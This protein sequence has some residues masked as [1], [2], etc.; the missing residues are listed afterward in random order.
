MPPGREAGL[1]LDGQERADRKNARVIEKLVA[2]LPIELT[3]EQRADLVRDFAAE[4]GGGK[5]PW[6]AAIHDKGKAE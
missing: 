6:L 5:V 4:I 2:A 1:W 3:P